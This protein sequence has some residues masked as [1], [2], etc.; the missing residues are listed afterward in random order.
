MTT[1]VDT[2]GG[3]AP[4]RVQVLGRFALRTAAG[5]V[6]R[7]DFGGRQARHLLRVLAVDQ[8]S[9]VTR[10]TLTSIL[11]PDR[12]PA[13]PDANLNVLVSRARH[14]AGEQRLIR[15]VTGGYALADPTL[16]AVDAFEFVRCADVGHDHLRN[17]NHAAALRHL[18]DA[19]DLWDE[20]LPEDAYQDWAQPHRRQLVARHLQVREDAATAALA[21]RDPGQAV[22]HA[23][24]ALREQP[25]REH[26]VGL[27][28]RALADG[29]DRAAALREFQAFRTRLV[30]ELGVDPSASLEDLH[31]RIL[32][33]E[34][35][36][37]RTTAVPPAAPSRPRLDFIGR[38][39]QLH[40][41]RSALQPPRRPVLVTGPSGAGK[42][43]LLEEVVR[44]TSTPTVTVE[45]VVAERTRGWSVVR[46]LLREVV[47]LDI[48]VLDTVPASARAALAPL[49]PELART[50]D[51]ARLDPDSLRSLRMEGAL[52]ALEA[53]S[54]RGLLVV[55]D[56]LQWADASSVA[57]LDAALARIDG[58]HAVL[59]LR[60][61]EVDRDHPATR[62]VADLRQGGDVLEIT[63][64]PLPEE[65]LA[66]I[67]GTD[68]LMQA[69]VR[70]TDA[71]PLAVTEALDALTTAGLVHRSGDRWHLTAEA[72]R[73]AVDAIVAAGQRRAIELRIGRQPHGR[74]RVLTALALLGREAPAALVADAL[75]R[76]EP[77]VL[78]D[79]DR[80]HV[81]SLADTGDRGWRTSHDLV[82]EV[83]ADRAE[84][85]AR[86]DLHRR[87]A[88]ALADDGADPAEL[89][90]HLGGA[91][92]HR[93][94]ARALG[95]AARGRLDE[96]ANQEARDLAD[97]ALRLAADHGH[98]AWLLELRAEARTRT[99][100]IAGARDDLRAAIAARTAGPERAHSLARLAIL[101]S[102]ADA[103]PHAEELAARALTE[104]R[105]DRAARAHALSVA[106]M[107]DV[108][109][110]HDGR[111]A[112]RSE[113][114]LGLF[115]A[116]GDARGVADILD[117]RAM[118]TFLDGRLGEAVELFARVAADF[119]DQ[120]EL[121]RVVTPR[122]TR[123]HGLL[124]MDRPEEALAE[125]DDALGL[126]RALGHA[127]GVTY[128][129][130]H[131]S[132][133]LAGLGRTDQARQAAEEALST[134]RALGHRGWTAT[135]LLARGTAA[136]AGGHLGDA[137]DAFNDARSTATGLPLFA[138]WARARLGLVEVRRGRLDAAQA[139]AA[140]TT[141]ATPGLAHYELLQLE[142]AIAAHAGADDAA[143]VCRRTIAT[144]EDGGHQR[145]ARALEDLLAALRQ[146]DVSTPT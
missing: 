15:T 111:A 54:D 94:A 34:V 89:G 48:S 104:A 103:L 114:A 29:G 80:L 21:L 74:R 13:D 18:L 28:L 131:R 71:T 100:D 2:P 136:A 137:A 110:G 85:G 30:E 22:H 140:E 107:I 77:D 146:R 76:A 5:E 121:L 16:C 112:E 98:E 6:P 88:E 75:G 20:P 87:L 64:G 118:A 72:G 124:F 4:V 81:A 113:E 105:D 142:A 37:T 9:V 86:T 127:E 67:V 115:T 133:V 125:V 106:A 132:E 42:S 23:R 83:A 141:E 65:A 49:V 134:A 45:A 11:W 108:N 53:V 143:A 40:A 128:T 117:G 32:R 52:R 63:L 120:G 47:E 66:R 43:R 122:S 60:P 14:A 99:D 24:A 129:Q 39:A 17:G 55:L 46:S 70:G 145:A 19:L 97:R 1:D 102:G 25:L 7:A 135:A 92:D 116:L 38:D 61:E 27:L 26:A 69:L 96:H 12:T 44:V 78:G 144:C 130:W 51:V 82:G 36:A 84:V 8:G 68:T 138:A 119:E 126:A 57:L 58:L 31:A 3:P 95:E 33:D 41:I 56:D 62:L 50:V 10:D 123:A 139:L 109:L 73:P 90:H 59:A 35:P 101:E 91:G 93:R 79:L